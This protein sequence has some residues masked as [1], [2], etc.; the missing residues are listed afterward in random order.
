MTSFIN[1]LTKFSLLCVYFQSSEL[2]SGYAVD[3]GTAALWTSALAAALGSLYYTFSPLLSSTPVKK[4]SSS[5]IKPSKPTSQPQQ[6]A[7]ALV[8][9]EKD[10]E[11]EKSEEVVA[12][13]QTIET[14]NNKES[15]SRKSRKRRDLTNK[16]TSTQVIQ[17]CNKKFDKIN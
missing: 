7:P 9:D 17:V 12:Q 5:S 8:K 16:G 1:S 10:E 6:P 3:A 4:S 14:T 13:N 15:K 2:W 11:M